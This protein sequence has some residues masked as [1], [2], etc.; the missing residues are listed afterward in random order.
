M[1]ITK[2]LIDFQLFFYT[3]ERVKQKNKWP[4]R[5]KELANQ[6]ECTKLVKMTESVF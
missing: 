4:I 5:C 2:V 3:W 6:R 1:N